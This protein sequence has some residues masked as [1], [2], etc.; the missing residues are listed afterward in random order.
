MLC[1]Q[2]CDKLID[3]DLFCNQA[4]D[5]HLAYPEDATDHTT[6]SVS[7]P[8][9]ATSLLDALSAS[10]CVLETKMVQALLKLEACQ[11]KAAQCKMLNAEE[12]RVADLDIV[13][14]IKLDFK[15]ARLGPALASLANL[16]IT[17]GNYVATLSDAELENPMLSAYHLK[18][19]TAKLNVLL[20]GEL[21]KAC[22]RWKESLAN[23]TETTDAAAPEHWKARVVDSAEKEYIESRVLS[24]TLVDSLG[25]DYLPALTWVEELNKVDVLL[26]AFNKRHGDALQKLTE[27][28]GD[29]RTLVACVLAYNVLY[30]RFPKQSVTE[31]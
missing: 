18:S 24:K 22:D 25:N 9:Q 21:A 28:L 6:L 4:N 30:N 15:E 10:D 23:V 13:Q 3:V 12:D 29:A 16:I 19:M 2:S 27:S 5:R 1:V 7:N 8:T 31:R 14:I 11:L 20:E 17:F 26:N